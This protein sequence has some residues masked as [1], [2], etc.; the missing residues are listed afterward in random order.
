MTT[1]MATVSMMMMMMMMMMCC[2]AQTGD[3]SQIMIGE[4]IINVDRVDT[5]DNVT[6]VSAT[7][8][9]VAAA[10]DSDNMMGDTSEEDEGCK[11]IRECIATTVNGRRSSSN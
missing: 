4:N 11:S 3:T 10:G 6:S 7:A 5:P 2:S 8:V 1:R 9:V